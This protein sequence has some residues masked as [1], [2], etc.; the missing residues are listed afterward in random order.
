M[1]AQ[2]QEGGMSMCGTF[3]NA[4]VTAAQVILW[5]LSWS[6]RPFVGEMESGVLAPCMG[7]C[8]SL[9]PS[10]RSCLGALAESGVDG[11]P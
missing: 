11:G 4:V 5:L 2:R 7:D 10:R 3:S 9:F 1:V 6:L 8:A